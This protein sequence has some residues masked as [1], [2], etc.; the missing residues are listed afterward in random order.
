MGNLLPTNMLNAIKDDLTSLLGEANLGS[1]TVTYYSLGL[2][3]GGSATINITTGAVTDPTTSA[4]VTAAVGTPTD[5]DARWAGVA[6]EV[7]DRVFLLQRSGLPAAPCS[8][9]VILYSGDLFSILKEEEHPTGLVVCY[10][11]VSGGEV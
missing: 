3:G 1:S 4:S 8:G 10:A 2:S 5:Q 9:D 7:T 6:L 11:R